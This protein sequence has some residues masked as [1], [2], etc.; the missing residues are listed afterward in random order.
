MVFSRLKPLRVKNNVDVIG[1]MGLIEAQQFPD[2]TVADHEPVTLADD[3]SLQKLKEADIVGRIDHFSWSGHSIGDNDLV[4]VVTP[5]AS[6]PR[7][8]QPHTPP[9]STAIQYADRPEQYF[10]PDAGRSGLDKSALIGV[11]NRFDHQ[12]VPH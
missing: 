1:R 6:G 2:K 4:N 5:D 11:G 12:N 10:Q 7:E 8:D 3:A 9:G